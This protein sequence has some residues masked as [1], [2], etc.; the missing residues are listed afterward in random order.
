M[1]DTSIG[2]AVSAV[3]DGVDA[4]V[5][6]ALWLRRRQLAI[7]N[8]N[9]QL[10]ALAGKESLAHLTRLAGAADVIALIQVS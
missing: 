2:S 10:A 3:F 5:T 8:K 4:R 1:A 7:K 9:L 6:V